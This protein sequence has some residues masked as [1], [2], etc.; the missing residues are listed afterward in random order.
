MSGGGNGGGNEFGSNDTTSVD[1]Q[2]ISIKT[3]IVSP[4]PTVLSTVAVGDDLGVQLR[5]ATGPLVAVTSGGNIL[6]SIFTTNPS[7]LI[8]CINQGYSYVAHVLS[9]SGADCQVL[10]TAI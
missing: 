9:I 5:S 8:T 1:C 2:K 10:I 6:G 7:L 4:N 3:S